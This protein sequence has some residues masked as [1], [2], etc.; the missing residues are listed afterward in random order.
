M[1]QTCKVCG[2]PAAG[3]H[4]GAFTC[5]GCKSF[6]GRSYNNLPS[7]SECKNNNECIINKKNRTSCKSC[8]LRKCLMVGMS[9]SGSRY[10]RRS[11][12][13]K[14]HCLLQEQQQQAEQ[15]TERTKLGHPDLL[16]KLDKFTNNNTIVTNNNLSPQISPK[17]LQY[18]EKLS[19]SPRNSPRTFPL[20][21]SISPSSVDA[22]MN[23]YNL[24]PQILLANNYHYYHQ[25]KYQNKRAKLD[26]DGENFEPGS[27]E[28]KDDH[29]VE[30]KSKE[31]EKYHRYQHGTRDIH[32]D[33]SVYLKNNHRTPSRN[34][35]G[36]GPHERYGPRSPQT[37][38][39][40]RPLDRA[41]MDL[42]DNEEQDVPIDLSIK[43]TSKR[44]SVEDDSDVDITTY[45]SDEETI[46]VTSIPRS[47]ASLVL[48]LSER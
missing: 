26:E 14:I 8:R 18:E 35:N 24:F 19:L 44:T 47:K 36:Y 22:N 28:H 29:H 30:D 37:H 23:Y 45:G 1:N 31:Y 16:L 41:D 34:H 6:F 32:N 13:F 9:K 40:N 17:S 2:E 33:H 21:H 43:S 12:W 46:D 25:F 48:D 20:D 4:F 39:D 38:Q 5:E 15:Q 3:F 10:G 27:E 42:S 11:N 7:I